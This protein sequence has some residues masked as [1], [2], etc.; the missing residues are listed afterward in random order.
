MVR[1]L[2]VASFAFETGNASNKAHSNV[3][4]DLESFI[5]SPRI[6]NNGSRTRARDTSESL[7]DVTSPNNGSR[8]RAR[9][10]SESFT[11]T[12][13]EVLKTASPNTLLYDTT[14]LMEEVAS[15]SRL[16]TR[17]LSYNDPAFAVRT[18]RTR[19]R[20]RLNP[21]KKGTHQL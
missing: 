12:F 9:D 21:D 7:P 19:L 1:F 4:Y 20:H 13:S 8:T 14:G 10:T 18:E 6:P 2:A 5:G 15:S 11:N 17:S 3:T 16:H